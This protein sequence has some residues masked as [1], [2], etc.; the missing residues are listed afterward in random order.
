MEQARKNLKISSMLVLLFVGLSLV[1]IV[2]GV[3]FVEPNSVPIPEGSPDNIL[4]ITKTFVMVIALVLMLPKIY[5][6]VK[7]LNVAKNPT[8]SKGHIIV[9][10]IIFVLSILSLIEPAMG[11]LKQDG[12]GSISSLFNILLEAIIY[13]EYIHYARIVAKLSE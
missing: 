4:L 2:T 1:Q 9:A 3:M 7:G 11:I 5:V 10:V 6:G 13:Y 8:A 12:S